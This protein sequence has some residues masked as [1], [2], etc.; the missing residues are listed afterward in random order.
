M[1]KHKPSIAYVLTGKKF[2][3]PLNEDPEKLKINSWKNG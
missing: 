1:P 2:T 3:L